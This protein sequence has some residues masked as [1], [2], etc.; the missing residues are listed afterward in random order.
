MVG[1][2]KRRRAAGQP[3]RTHIKGSV[4]HTGSPK[5]RAGPTKTIR[6]KKTYLESED[7]PS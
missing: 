4:A 3:C 1:V 2:R 6:F 5:V 7:P